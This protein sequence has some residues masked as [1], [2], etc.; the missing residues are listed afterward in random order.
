MGAWSDKKHVASISDII[1]HLVRKLIMAMTMG[2]V[3]EI[4]IQKDSAM[5]VMSV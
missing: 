5:V 2:K 1:S 4:A 3:K